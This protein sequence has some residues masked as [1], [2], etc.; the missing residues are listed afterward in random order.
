MMLQ[1]S[2]FTFVHA[3]MLFLR[4]QELRRVGQFWAD[5]ETNTVFSLEDRDFAN[6]LLSQILGCHNS[7]W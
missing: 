3:W 5:I 6:K 4:R 1:G 2:I 7:W